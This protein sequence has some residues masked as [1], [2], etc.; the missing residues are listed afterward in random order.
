M[1]WT[2]LLECA[3]GSFYVGSTHDLETRL[4]QHAIGHAGSYTA[5]RRPVKLVWAEEFE[6]IGDAWAA[7]RR[8]HGWSRAKKL[9]FI[10][11]RSEDLRRLSRNYTQFGKFT[12]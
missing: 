6:H 11:G 1:P 10:E 8:I 9:A 2:Y 4:E 3:D 7:E 12:E 5:T